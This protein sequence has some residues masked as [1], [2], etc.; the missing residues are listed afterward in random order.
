M[1]E[2]VLPN[3]ANIIGNL[4]GGRLLHWIDLAGV[5]CATRHA[6]SLAATVMIDAVSFKRPI[7]VG[8]IVVLKS[9]VTWTGKTSIE[10]AIEVYAENPYKG[11]RSF[12]QKTYAVFVTLNEQGQ[13]IPVVSYVPVT[14]EEQAEF[15]AGIARQTRRTAPC[16]CG[17]DRHPAN[18]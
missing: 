7:R 15:D 3:D 12:I 17:L 5:T 8:S 6:E 9:Y 2:M 4:L 10:T 14:A 11:E 16:H 13:K 18:L 1:T